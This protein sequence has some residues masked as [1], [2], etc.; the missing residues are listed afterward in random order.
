MSGA[1]MT[2][3]S[4][5]KDADNIVK[6]VMLILAGAS[7]WGWALIFDKLLTF[8]TLFAKTS[9]FEKVFWSGQ[10]LNQLY[11]RLKDKADHPFAFI[12]ISAMQ[13]LERHK[14]ENIK[15]FNVLDGVKER[16]YRAMEIARNKQ[17][18][19]LE[20]NVSFLATIG[21]AS[22]FI[23]LFGTVWGIM[24]SFQS[25]AASKN[26][27]LSIVAPGIAEALLATAIGLVAAIPAVI[28]YNIISNKLTNF[29]Y[30]MDNFIA[31]LYNV[32]TKEIDNGAS[33]WE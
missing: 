33:R 7:F 15:N 20:N 24:H 14:L 11:N 8:K 22:P 29:T 28:F 25:I 1:E 10:L 31:Q 27:S 2:I 5:I 13:E 17:I 19:A 30:K 6:L 23:G 4:L 9:H 26:T 12:F 18:E 32:I 21:S 3:I 16:I